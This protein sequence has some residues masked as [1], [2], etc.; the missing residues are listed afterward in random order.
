[1]GTAIRDIINL[2]Q[3]CLGSRQ[4]A[5]MHIQCCPDQQLHRPCD[6]LEHP[7]GIILALKKTS[8]P[9]SRHYIPQNPRHIPPAC[10]HLTQA[11]DFKVFLPSA[12][13]V[14]N[15]EGQAESQHSLM[16]PG[17]RVCCQ[18]LW[19]G[20]TWYLMVLLSVKGCPR[21]V[22]TMSGGQRAC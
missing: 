2:L 17:Y 11:P 13:S 6:L 20:W 14:S 5:G 16:L 10:W 18:H 3:S 15:G 12:N 1:M 21:F 4:D 8:N 19:I 22:R 9:F 7:A